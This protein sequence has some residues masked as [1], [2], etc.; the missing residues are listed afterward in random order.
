MPRH[1]VCSHEKLF[2]ASNSD[3]AKQSKITCYS[4]AIHWTK[5]TFS[6]FSVIF[7]F[8]FI[9]FIIIIIIIFLQSFL[10]LQIFFVC[11]AWYCCIMCRKWTLWGHSE[12]LLIAMLFP[13]WLP[14]L[15]WSFSQVDNR[16]YCLLIHTAKVCIL[17]QIPVWARVSQRPL[18]AWLQTSNC[19]ILYLQVCVFRVLCRISFSLLK[20]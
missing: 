9:Y 16:L 1:V 19:A 12:Y 15:L 18:L 3:S 5:L 7:F 6:D 2:G 10:I 17:K 13:L 8:L 20:C 14:T 11:A 4:M